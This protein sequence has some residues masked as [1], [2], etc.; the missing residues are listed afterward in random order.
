MLC[1]G[2]DL[3]GIWSFG[4]WWSDFRR[5]ALYKNNQ[6]VFVPLVRMPYSNLL[7]A[8]RPICLPSLKWIFPGRQL[9]DLSVRSCDH[10]YVLTILNVHALESEEVTNLQPAGLKTV[11]VD[12]GYLF[13]L[14]LVHYP[15]QQCCGGSIKCAN[16]LGP[17]LS[18]T[19]RFA[20]V[21]RFARHAGSGLPTS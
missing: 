20:L 2:F 18:P 4:S 19:Q 16:L 21:F 10:F 13:E 5:S 11:H 15:G 7:V 6:Y 9:G 3:R 17:P 12:T 8:N 1:L 14:L